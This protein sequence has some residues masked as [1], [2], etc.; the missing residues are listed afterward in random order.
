MSSF[1][2][3]VLA[4]IASRH[5]KRAYLNQPVPRSLLEDVLTAAAN[6]PSSKNTQPWGVAVLTGT[7]LHELSQAMCAKFDQGIVESPDYVYMPDPW[8][9]GFKERAREVGYRLFELKGIERHD[10]EQRQ[11]HDREN[12]VFFGAP[13]LLIFHL[14]RTAEC[15]M[16]LDMGMFMENVMLGLLAHGVA[17]CPQFSLTSYSQT[18]REQLDLGEDRLV[19]AGLAVGYPDPTALVNTFIP[20]RLPL[21][22][23]TRWYD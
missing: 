14:H 17:S 10:R 7:T 20:Q 8:P 9:P 18:I 19:V 22:E 23:Y 5:S 3:Q 6:A 16:F 13:L 15:G 2:D 21:K 11:A 1:P 12:F 4:L